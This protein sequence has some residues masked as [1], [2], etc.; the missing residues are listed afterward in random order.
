M[1]DRAHSLLMFAAL[2]LGGYVAARFAVAKARSMRFRNKVVVITGGSRGLG[3]LLARRFGAEGAR[4][5]IASREQVEL[6]RALKEL[7]QR[8]YNVVATHCDV[9]LKNDVENLIRTA[10]EHFGGVDVLINNAG[11]ISVGPFELM[12]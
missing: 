9:R 1:E 11:V 10:V 7:Q 3:L 6:D 8:G 2:A 5:I 12:T 4:L